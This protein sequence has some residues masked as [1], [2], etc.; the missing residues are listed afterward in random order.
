MKNYLLVCAVFICS[1]VYA[2]S[3]NQLNQETYD[4][5]DQQLV[6]T[7]PGYYYGIWFYTEGE[8]NDWY[9]QKFKKNRKDGS[10]Y[11]HGQ[12]THYDEN[13]Y[14]I[15]EQQNDTTNPNPYRQRQLEKK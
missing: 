9:N 7:G 11:K 5:D 12:G 10:G 8:Y 13:G 6:W 4:E 15:E 2:Q 3:N 14:P 1:G